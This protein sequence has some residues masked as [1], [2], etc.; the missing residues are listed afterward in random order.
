[1]FFSMAFSQTWQLTKVDSTQEYG[2]DYLFVLDNSDSN[3]YTFNLYNGNKSS[4]ISISDNRGDTSLIS[5]VIIKR[6]DDG[7]EESLPVDMNGTKKLMLDSGS[8]LIDIST[9]G[10]DRF[11]LTFKLARNEYMDLAV[12]LGEGMDLGDCYHIR[13]KFELEDSEILRI[14]ACVRK[15][16]TKRSLKCRK[17]KKFYVSKVM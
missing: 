17:K 8:Y 10:Y 14:M 4:T 16:K 1:M 9:I 15:S 6:L 12:K 3:S 13:S 11:N 7:S 2:Y 5:I